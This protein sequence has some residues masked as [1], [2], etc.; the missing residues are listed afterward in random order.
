MST[1]VIDNT[2]EDPTQ[3]PPLVLNHD[4]FDTVTEEVCRVNEEPKPP[5]AWYI[6][7]G[8]SGAL[9]GMLTGLILYL[10][11]TGVGVWG[12]NN[13]VMW[14][15]PIVNFVFWVGIGHA[16]TLISAILFLFRQR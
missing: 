4:R 14:G 8:I 11:G 10:F 9:A 6:A 1:I 2:F 16:G 3:R 15:F 5:K 13:P 7:L 12:N